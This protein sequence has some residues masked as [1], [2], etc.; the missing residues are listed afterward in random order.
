MATPPDDPFAPADATIF[1]PRPGRRPAVPH[2][3]REPPPGPMG[4]QLA[5]APGRYLAGVAV[6]SG[7]EFIAAGGNPVLRSAV[8]LLVL[9]GRLRGQIANADVDSLR[10]QCAQEIRAFE[11]RLRR[12]NVPTED[13]L[14]A[15]Y[16]MCTV[17]DEAVLNT[18][19]G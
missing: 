17:I 7:G 13:V 2:P 3:G 11:D 4:A 6:P 10:R 12:A 5:A 18:P 8:P 15:R 9:A 14:A 1:R 16:A 19:W